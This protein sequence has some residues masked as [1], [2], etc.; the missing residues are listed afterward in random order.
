MIPDPSHPMPEG[1]FVSEAITPV[2]GTADAS[3][4]GRGEP[5]LPNR[6]TWRDREYAI[7]AVLDAW[8]S[9]SP[10]GGTGRLYLRRH[11]YR[12]RTD[13]GRLMTLYCERQAR[14]ARQAK[15]RWWLY[16]VK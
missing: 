12:V 2:P 5:G 13:D 8:K 14:S 4:M 7:T 15:N 3:A 9:S 6:F 11:W 16:A 1:E 10:E